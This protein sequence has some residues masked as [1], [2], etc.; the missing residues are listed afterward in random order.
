MEK[1]LKL[2]AKE[3]ERRLEDLN[4]EAGRIK[5]VQKESIPREVFDRMIDSLNEKFERK[6]T[7]L[8]DWKLKQESKLDT[9]EESKVDFKS[10]IALIVSIISLI[11]MY[12]KLKS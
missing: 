9:K 10:Y 7:I 3:Y 11:F 4:G 5:D 6:I 1:A 2:Q 8:N 12:L